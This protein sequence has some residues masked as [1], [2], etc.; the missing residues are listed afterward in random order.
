MAK[1]RNV[2]G[3]T[4]VVGYGFTA[5]RTVKPDEVL[6]VPPDVA[7]AY[8][9]QPGIWNPEDQA[10]EDAEARRAVL[11]PAPAPAPAPVPASPAP[12]AVEPTPVS[13]GAAQ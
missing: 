9:G 8:A 5:R 11:D 6:V 7:E 10:A 12:A 2:S 4:L 13:E 1:F 3:E